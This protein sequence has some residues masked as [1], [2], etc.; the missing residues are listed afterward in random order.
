MNAL[1]LAEK[2]HSSREYKYKKLTDEDRRYV[3]DLLISMPKIKATNVDFS[4][5]E[6]GWELA[7]QLEGIAGYFGHMITAPHYFALLCEEGETCHKWVGYLGEWF[8]LNALKRSIG[9]C[10]IEVKDVPA[11]KQLLQ[12][13]S[14]KTIAALIAFG[15]PK[16]E[17]Q[18]SSLY[19]P[20]HPNSLSSLTDLGYP[21]ID[22][23][24]NEGPISSRKA[25]TEF[26]DHQNY[27]VSA[28]LKDL[29]QLGLHRAFFYMRL[30]PS[31]HNRQ[32][33]H[34]VIHGHDID[35]IIETSEEVPPVI[36]GIDAGIA[37]LYFQVGLYDAGFSGDWHTDKLSLDYEL[38]T[39][40]RLV[41][42]W[43]FS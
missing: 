16:K 42:K 1:K 30:A 23:L 43:V 5:V 26:V 20:S 41:A 3:N 17:F 33:W 36:Q 15:Y 39:N 35:L 34:F 29:E 25:I 9:S 18:S 38:P 11:V 7:P 2:R 24:S 12:I 28:T 31:Y 37:M 13:E 22:G 8:I 27:G 10:W 19:S 21:N 14:P 6:D 40:K 32:P 4:F